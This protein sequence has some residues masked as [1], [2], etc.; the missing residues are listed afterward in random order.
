[1]PM[2]SSTKLKIPNPRA[3]CSMALGVPLSKQTSSFLSLKDFVTRL[4][5]MVYTDNCNCLELW[6]IGK[7]T[8]QLLCFG[9]SGMCVMQ[10][11]FTL[12]QSV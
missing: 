11:N 3:L 12:K 6:C 8:M 5:G 9:V 10:H 7:Q 2:W 4:Q 1:L